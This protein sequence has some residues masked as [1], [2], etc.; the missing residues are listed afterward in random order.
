MSYTRPILATVG[1]AVAIGLATLNSGSAPETVV[2]SGDKPRGKVWAKGGS[3][4]LKAGTGHGDNTQGLLLTLNGD[5]W[6]GAGLNWHGWYPADAGDDFS[7]AAALTFWVRQHSELAKADL[8]VQLVDNVKRDDPKPVSNPVALVADGILPK[9]DG[10][11]RKAVIPLANFAQ[12]RPLRLDRLW[13]VDF[14]TTTA[15]RLEVHLDRIA[16]GRGEANAAPVRRFPETPGYK[17]TIRVEPDKVVRRIPDEI[18]GTADLA[19]ARQ[20]AFALPVVRW[21]GNRT[22]RYNWK[23]G[24]DSAAA[25]WFFLNGGKPYRD[26]ASG[27]YVAAAREAKA[28]GGALYLT[29]PMLGW[30]AKDGTSYGFSVRKYGEQKA[31]EPDKPDVG[32][33]IRPDGKPVTGNDPRDTSVPADADFIADAVKLCVEKVGHADEGGVRYWV[34]DNEPMLWHVTHR[35]VSPTPLGAE[36]LWKRTVAYAEA[37]KKADPSAKVA[38]FVSW[39]WMDLFYSARD[40]GPDNYRTK[41]DWAAHGSQPLAEWFIR[42]CGEYKRKHGRALVDIFDL[43]WYPQGKVGDRGVYLGKGADVELNALRLRSTRDLWDPAYVPESWI[44]DVTG[45]STEVLR[46]VRRWIDKYNP[47][48]QVC[49]GEYNFGGADTVAGGLAQADLF[50]VFAREGLDLAFIWERPEGS[51]ELAWRLY[52]NHDGQGGRFGNRL[53]NATADHADLAVHAARRADGALTAVA[54]NKSLGGPCELTLHLGETGKLRAHRFDQE[55]GNAVRAA[56]VPER[57]EAGP[58]SLTLPPA[59]ATMFVVAPN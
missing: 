11:W 18:Y 6:R 45:E 19:D 40:Q 1:L 20:K 47:G 17:A 4:V 16:F 25:D 22:S 46:R 41:P 37:I 29:V 50:G 15:G 12:G 38:G 14:S 10:T 21:G 8:A 49:L 7:A 23:I 3:L 31:H 42:R 28:K 39:G 24:C 57:A 36:E 9:L 51:Q 52:R 59:S 26:P 56:S 32:N 5:G 53:V 58:L 35:D 54:I 43:H 44:R 13:G 27:G 48:M 33:G 2:W 30:V 55:S 34:L